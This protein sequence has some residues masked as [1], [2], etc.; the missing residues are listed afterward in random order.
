[1]PKIKNEIYKSF[2]ESNSIIEDFEVSEEQF[3]EWLDTIPSSKQPRKSTPLQA[4]ALFI[5]LFWTGRRPSELVTL[6]PEH[7]NKVTKKGRKFLL[8]IPTLKG[9]EQTLIPLPFNK[10]TLQAYNYMK[11]FPPGFNCFYAFLGHRRNKVNM[12]LRKTKIIKIRTIHQ[13]GTITEEEQHETEREPKIYFKQGEALGH[14]CLLWTGRPA[15]WFRHYRFS[16]MA[17]NGASRDQIKDYK[18]AKTDESVKVYLHQSN[19]QIN[20]MLKTIKF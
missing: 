17:K 16:H 14:Y 10:H 5:L 8:N 7:I 19:K 12:R 2:R 1:M 6:R 20:E 4:Q 9:G 18:G 15:Y 3:Q 11:K 13:D